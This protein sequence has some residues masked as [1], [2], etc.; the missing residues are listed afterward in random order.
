MPPFLGVGA[1]MAMLDALELSDH[2]L[3][4]RFVDLT[5]AV[6]AFEQSMRDRMVPL[7]SGSLETQ[8]LLFAEDAPKSLMARFPSRELGD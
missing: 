4:D 5:E 1:D 7:I 2:L 3:S 8:D 6:E